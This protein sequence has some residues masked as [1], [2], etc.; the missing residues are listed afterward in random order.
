[1]ERI[2]HQICGTENRKP[3]SSGISQWPGRRRPVEAHV[4]TVESGRTLREQQLDRQRPLFLQITPPIHTPRCCQGTEARVPMGA[5]TGQAC[6]VIQTY[7]SIPAGQLPSAATNPGK[8]GRG[9]SLS[10]SLGSVPLLNRVWGC[11][12]HTPLLPRTLGYFSML[13]HLV[14]VVLSPPFPQSPLLCLLV[15]SLRAPQSPCLQPTLGYS[16]QPGKIPGWA[17]AQLLL[18]SPG[19]KRGL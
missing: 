15:S 16:N 9:G 11:T 5:E 12:P 1:M 13:A 14:C 10:S 18:G 2:W 4:C 6:V 19:N 8:G 17:L 3:S 7:T